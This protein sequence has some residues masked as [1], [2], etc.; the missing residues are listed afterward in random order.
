MTDC[1]SSSVT[2]FLKFAEPKY[3]DLQNALQELWEAQIRSLKLI[4]KATYT[5]AD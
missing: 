1:I 5:K 3:K 4:L 2:R